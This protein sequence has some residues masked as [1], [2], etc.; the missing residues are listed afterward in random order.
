MA[1]TVDD[2]CDTPALPGQEYRFRFL[3]FNL[4]NSQQLQSLEQ[5][6]GLSQDLKSGHDVVFVTLPESPLDLSA[7]EALGLA[8][9]AAESAQRQGRVQGL[10]EDI[11]ARHNGDMQTLLI[12]D[13]LFREDSEGC[14]GFLTDDVTVAGMRVPNPKKAFLGRSLAAPG[15][16]RFGL[17]GAHFPITQL[18]DILDCKDPGRTEKTISTLQAAKHLWAGILRLVL[19]GCA[20][21]LRM[22]RSKTLLF[23]QGDLNSRTIL[24][25]RAKDLLL[26]VLKDM[27]LQRAI[28]RSGMDL[29]SGRWYEVGCPEAES[30]G[31]TSLPVTYK[32][33]PGSASEEFRISDVLE[34]AS[35]ARLFPSAQDRN[36]AHSPRKYAET[37]TDAEEA[38]G[39]WGLA[40]KKSSFRAFRFPA[41]A[42][43]MIFWAPDTLAPRLRW[44]L[45]EKG[46][47]VDYAH[48]GSDHKPVW[49]DL[50][51][52]VAPEGEEP[53]SPAEAEPR[54][55]GRTWTSQS[56]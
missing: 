27:P 29:P 45:P 24:E 34:A 8:S 25:G 40:F 7:L 1:L 6:K 3:T 43:R 53:T 19:R 31:A 44:D 41:C 37:L 56:G 5:I 55:M 21:Q 17:V 22:D 30:L 42:D 35:Q 49:L 12:F 15:G 32:F 36:S 23:L 48:Q 13:R 51:L 50:V 38:V 54:K 14:F 10:L 47:R 11:A 4:A 28:Q 16:L 39:R 20:K 9:S 2:F 26:E 18:A 46:Y 52:H 33:Q